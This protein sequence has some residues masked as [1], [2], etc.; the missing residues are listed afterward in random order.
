MP[1][2]PKPDLFERVSLAGTKSMLYIS[3][4]ASVELVYNK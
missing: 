2:S 4:G 1:H 3:S